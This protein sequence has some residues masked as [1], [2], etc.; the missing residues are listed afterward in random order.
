MKRK[1]TAS[2]NIAKAQLRILFELT[3]LLVKL[4]ILTQHYATNTKVFKQNQPITKFR[5]LTPQT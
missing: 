5:L 4:T 3:I 2:N 1:S